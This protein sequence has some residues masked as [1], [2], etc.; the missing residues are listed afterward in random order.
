M[1]TDTSDAV[2]P[3]DAP[4]T[5]DARAL[6]RADDGLAA[7]AA[8]RRDRWY[9]T[10]HIAAPGGWINDPNG[11]SYF[12]GRWHAFFQ[13][14][15]FGTSWG[16]MHWGHVSSADLV[17]W[18][19][20]PV[21][22]APSLEAERAG[23]YSGSAVVGTDGLL[24]LLYTAH[25][26]RNG[27]DEGAGNLEVQCA[28]T[29]RDGV[30]FEKRGVVVGNPDGLRDFRDPKVWR[31]GDAWCMVVGRQ[32]PDGRGEIV[33]YTS[34]DLA[35]WSWGGVLYRS[36]DESVRMLECP[37]LF[38]LVSPSGRRRWALCFSAM[39]ARPSGYLMRN[40]DNAGYLVGTW[41]PGAPFRPETGFLPLDW[42]QNFYAPQTMGAPD[43]RR[44]MWGWMRPAGALPVQDDGW[45]G[46][47]TV[48][49]EVT[50]A[51]DGTL[52]FRPARELAALRTESG[53][54][55]A[56]ELAPD[57]VR[58][59][60][61]DDGGALE[62]E[63][64][65]DLAAS[66]AERAGLCVHATPD[67]CHTLVAYDDQTGRV[68]LDRHAVGAGERG[69]RAAPLGPGELAD[70]TLVL[71]VLIDRGSVEAFVNDGTQ[72]LSAYSLPSDG[73][74]A[75]RLVSEGGTLAV[76]S[77][78]WHRLRSIGLDGRASAP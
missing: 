5:D 7:L 71:R 48:P 6:E 52:R 38:E 72:T 53:V 41:E 26:W 18:R 58:T 23:V 13:L 34:E 1:S 77:L 44:L 56:T 9:P 12:R 63:L 54:L 11:L 19:R 69:Y 17:T 50:L 76:R 66:T 37:D 70:G 31:Q 14:H 8:R 62:V 49:R 15:P 59:V 57:E 74:R 61:E 75:V 30:R 67:G 16:P 2:A 24:H 45:C 42:G 27:R 28:A 65:L 32:A 64:T 21:A 60:L 40:R 78:V 20:E 55:G 33:L 3:D 46:Q 73:P 35:S 43:G 25:R 39:G 10:F 36:P 47:L 51:D 4:F 68:V 22:L 29:S